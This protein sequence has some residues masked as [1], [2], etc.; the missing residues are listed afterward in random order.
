MHGLFSALLIAAL[1]AAGAQTIL[2]FSHTDQ[3]DV[4]SPRGGGAPR[5]EGRGPHAGQVRSSILQ[6]PASDRFEAPYVA[7][8]KRGGATIR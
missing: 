7:S 8:I 5:K 2:R 4:G 6:L 1:F 3:R